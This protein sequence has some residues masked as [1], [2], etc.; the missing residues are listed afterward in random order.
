MQLYYW[1]LCTE[2]SLI[3]CASLMVC[4]GLAFDSQP[5]KIFSVISD[6]RL[7]LGICLMK[8]VPSGCVLQRVS[9]SA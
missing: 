7:C 1:A 4:A 2:N 6:M 9:G 3:A 5:I 8:H